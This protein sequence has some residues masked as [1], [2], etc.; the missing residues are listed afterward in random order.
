LTTAANKLPYFNG[1]DTATTTDLSAFGRSLIDDADAATARTTL[2]LAT[3]ATTTVGT[4]AT[5]N[6]NAVA[7]TGGAISG[8]TD[9]AIA[10]GGTGASDA[11]T[12]RTN[13]GLGNVNNTSDA[14]KPIS[15]A[16]QTALDLKSN[17]ATSVQKDNDTGSAVIPSGTTAQRTAAPTYGRLRANT[18]LNSMEWWNGTVWTPVGSG[19]G[20]TGAGVALSQDQIFN[21]TD[22]LVTGNWTIG[23]GSMQTGV[24]VTIASPAVFTFTGH[25]L[26]ADQPVRFTTT[27]ALPTG[28]IANERYYVLAT[29]LT[30]NTFRVS[31][32]IG[33]TAVNTS[34]TQSGTHSFGKVK[35]ALITKELNVNS[36]VS[37]TV[38]SG[39]SMVIV[40]GSGSS[41]IPDQY[42]NTFSDQTI[43]GVKN[44]TSMPTVNGLDVSSVGVNQTW[45]NLI[46]SRT[47]GT[48]YTNTTGR[49][50]VVT[51]CSASAAS[52]G[53]SITVNGIL[54]AN[55][56]SN[57]N[58]GG[59]VQW[60]SAIVPNGN[61]YSVVGTS[62]GG[63][64]E[65]R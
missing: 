51:A 64:V 10:D 5:Q 54:N 45:Q 18:T 4:I 62:L 22:Q 24:T 48:T 28:L 38:P 63:W 15:T 32:T 27:G 21:E 37:V 56:V 61:T 9:L 46:G 2:G 57:N 47:L 39:S 17:L 43:G 13:L 59:A 40:G 31:L 12:A 58:V 36:G 14:S 3:G 65:L 26:V 42:V 11:A 20:A 33:G 41:S 19:A 34:G 8:I 1:V 50:I 16:T 53:F 44:F 55:G 35:N 52:I 7:I 29:G 23:Q 30:A 49:P 25:S 60:C 6:S